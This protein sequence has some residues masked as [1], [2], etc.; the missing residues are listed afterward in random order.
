MKDWTE[1]AAT[2]D[3]LVVHVST[4]GDDANDGLSPARP[5]RTIAA[6]V[7]LLRHGHPD[8]LRLRRGDVFEGE[9][10]GHWKKSGRSARLPMVVS[11]YGE[12]PRRP[13]L[14]TPAD[15]VWTNGGGGSPATIENLAIVGLSLR[16]RTYTGGGDVVG[17]R[18]LQ[19]GANIL[20][21]DCE[22]SGFSTNLVLQAWDGRLANYSVRRCVISDA[23]VDHARSGEHAQGLYAYGVDH[24][25][26][27]ENVWDHNGWNELVPGAGAD[28]YSHNLYIDND[29]T[30]VRVRGN[31]IARA[32]SH[33]MQ[34]R[35][36]GQVFGNLF[37]RNSINLSVGM[38]NTPEPL[39]VLVECI[40]NLILDGKDIDE[41]NPRG[42][43]L[44]VGNV[45]GGRILYNGILGNRGGTQ[46]DMLTVDGA[47][48]LEI[49]DNVIADWGGSVT[50]AG[51][52]ARNRRIVF[53]RN[54]IGGRGDAPLVRHVEASTATSA[55][56]RSTGN[57]FSVAR[58]EPW[59]EVAGERRT[60]EQWTALTEDARSR[61]VDP[62]GA[63]ALGEDLEEFMHHARE[64]SRVHWDPTHTAFGKIERV[65]AENFL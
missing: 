17:V 52:A 24:L 41:R 62:I 34:L 65:R 42:W 61:A 22:V 45:S 13:R 12:D 27:E 10:L 19:P 21:E 9:S 43:G 31:V 54:R 6:G 11:T 46:P 5:R 63:L 28:I 48:D 49:A 35:C 47:R 23:Y 38:G 57:R 37:L 33:G 39:G 51:D 64:Q 15:G 44:Q 8:H 60:L 56:L 30:S 26:L 53:R 59:F 14:L 25:L 1:L 29:C 55:V 2:S 20:I 32:A 7:A 36:G 50:I 3:A 40:G 4:G 18:M 58:G 16:P